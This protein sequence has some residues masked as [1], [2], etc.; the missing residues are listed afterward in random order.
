MSEANKTLIY[1]AVAVL[2]VAAAFFGRPDTGGTPLDEGVGKP[3]FPWD[4]PL[5]ATRLEITKFDSDLAEIQQFEVAQKNGLWVI[6]SHQNYPADAE[7]KIQEVATAFIDL[8]V[9]RLAS[10]TAADHEQLGV[11]EPDKDKVEVGAEGVGMKVVMR[12]AEGSVLAG[13]IVGK[14]VKDSEDQRFVREVGR[15]AV[16]TVKIDPDE[17]STKFEDWIAADLLD[18]NT[19]DVKQVVLKDYSV[20]PQMTPQGVMVSHEQRLAMT[21]SVGDDN[22]SWDL[23]ELLEFRGGQLRPTSLAD[24]E[25]LN[26]D[27]LDGLK[28]ALGDL[29][30]VNVERKPKGLGTDLKA[31]KEF[32]NDREAME[33]LIKRGFFPLSDTGDVLSSDGEVLVNTKDGVQYVLRFGQVAGIGEGDEGD[34]NRFLFVSTRVNQD[35]FPPPELEDVPK[36]PA[37]DAVEEPA[38]D[39]E[40]S[41][42]E[43]EPPAP[44]AETPADDAADGEAAPADGEAAPADREAAPADGESAP[45]DGEA[46]PADGEAAPAD[47]EADAAEEPAEEDPAQPEKPDAEAIQAEIERVT[48]DNQRKLDEFNENRDK[49]EKRVDELNYRFADWYYVIDE[50]VFKKIRLNRPDIIKE[51]ETATV[52]GFGIDAFRKLEDEGVETIEEPADDGMSGMPPGGMPPGGMPPRG[53]PPRGMPPR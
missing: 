12:D 37:A 49:A 15:N 3:L 1:V 9:Q 2:V 31:N 50:E 41:P 4:D 17:F 27:R 10:T 21:V 47:G 18:L 8:Q 23:D 20:Q 26:T 13:L 36:L 29:K 35:H 52:E 14:K 42:A 53:M 11:V 5:K 25:E 16:Y 22:F 32:L 6:P 33:S 7:D 40:E 51:K 48:K 28:T 34:L 46:A 44:E 45:T 38:E 30:I 19:M 24:D 39:G 43:G